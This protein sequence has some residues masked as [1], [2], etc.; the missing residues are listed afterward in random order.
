MH[1]DMVRFA[2]DFGQ[3]LRDMPSAV[4]DA[5]VACCLGLLL[6]HGLNRQAELGHQIAWAL[7]YL[8]QGL[9]L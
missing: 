6:Y 7:P 1:Q 3:V 4:L 9:L 5:A 2:V 8:S